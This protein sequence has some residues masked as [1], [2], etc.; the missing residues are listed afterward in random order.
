MKKKSL[1]IT[2]EQDIFIKD[3]PNFNFGAWVREMLDDYIKF[4][5]GLKILDGVKE[6]E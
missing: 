2:Y 5:G 3:H 4:I 1:D 6:F